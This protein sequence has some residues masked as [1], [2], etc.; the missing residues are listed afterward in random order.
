MI[1]ELC[2]SVL[3]TYEFGE[4]SDWQPTGS[5]YKLKQADSLFIVH[6]FHNLQEHNFIIHWTNSLSVLMCSH[7]EHI[8]HMHHIRLYLPEPVDLLAVLGVMS[9]DSVLLP[10]GQINL[11][12]PTQHQL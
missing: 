2:E 4:A 3:C 1:V 7:M 12:H 6:L 8:L 10:V 5:C 9:I 11:L